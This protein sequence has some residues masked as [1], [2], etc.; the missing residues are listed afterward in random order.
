ML[1]YPFCKRA[2][3]NITKVTGF[4]GCHNLKKTRWSWNLKIVDAFEKCDSLKKVKLRGR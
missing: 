1:E 4:Y 2:E 3:E